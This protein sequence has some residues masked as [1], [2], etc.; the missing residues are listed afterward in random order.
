VNGETIEARAIMLAPGSS[1]VGRWREFGDRILTSDTLFEQVDLPRRIAVIG[2]SALMVEIAKAPARLGLEVAGLDAVEGLAV[3]DDA[4]VLAAFRP[5]IEAELALH[6]GAPAEL[7]DAGDAIRVTGA[8]GAFEADAVVAAIGR[9]PNDAR[10]GTGCVRR[11]R[12]RP[13][14]LRGDRA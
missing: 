5:L 14:G 4:E 2:M 7:E 11:W 12:I 1:P 13:V 10:S 6:L 8:G 3:I 9:R